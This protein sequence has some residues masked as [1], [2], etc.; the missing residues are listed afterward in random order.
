MTGFVTVFEINR[1]SNGLLADA[2][3]RLFVGVAVLVGGLVGAIRIWRRP[4]GQSRSGLAP[5]LFAILWAVFWLVL[6]NFPRMYG[7]IDALTDAYEHKR[8]EVVEG[9]VTVLNE[10]PEHGHSS[11]DRI[12]VGGKTFEVSYFSATPAYRQ[13]IAHGGALQNGA[14][15]RVGYVGGDIVRIE[16]RKR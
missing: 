2:L 4:Y 14:Y 3:F 15:A 7:R 8:Y 6:H 13:T 11:G 10:Q 12:A 1:W 5:C 16:I 9:V